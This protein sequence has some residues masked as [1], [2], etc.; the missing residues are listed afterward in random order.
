MSRTGDRDVDPD[1]IQD[2]I[3]SK[4]KAGL[5]KRR[6]GFDAPQAAV[7]AIEWVCKL[8]FT[9]ALQKERSCSNTLKASLQSKAQR[10]LFFAERLALKIPDIPKDTPLL[11]I[12]KTGVIGAGTMGAGIAICLLNADFPVVLVET[13]QDALD[14]GLARIRR[15][16]D[17]DV[18]RGRLAAE[19]RD[20]RLARLTGALGL[21]ALGSVDFVV[22]AAFESMEVKKQIFSE[23]DSIC[24]ETA[25]L[26]TNTST[27][28]INDIS[29]ITKSPDRVIGTHFFSPANVM[30]LLEVIRGEKTAKAVVA[31]TMKLGRRIGK[32]PALSGVGYGFIGN[33]MLED[34]VRESQMLLLEGASPAQVDGALEAWGMAMGPCAVMDLAG[35]DVSFLTRD[36]NRDLLPNDPLYC[37]PGD[38]MNAEGR[39]GQKTGKGFYQY[40]DGRTRQNDSEAIDL[41]GAAAAKLGIEKRDKISDQESLDR[42]LHALINRGAQLLDDGIALRAS[43]IDV[44]WSA[45]YGFPAY[46]GGPMFY[47]DSIGLDVIVQSFESL[48]LKF[49][50][51]YGYWTPAPLLVNLAKSGKTFADYDSDHK[52][53]T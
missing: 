25:I 53:G 33:R 14:H 22:E 4:A 37:V 17:R 7:D 27:L 38:I 29:A 48:A 2:E 15:A 47:A 3:F 21:E 5:A 28:D 40:P 32:V 35:Q 11:D 1:S 24:K 8:P 49:G 23:L 20:E 12:A 44:V 41:I 10:H 50:N 42:C 31:T 34:Y 16:F 39:F 19:V 52:G 30:K 45:G 36:Q 13:K 26:A 43:D 51:D 6:R 9:E 46:R 18:D